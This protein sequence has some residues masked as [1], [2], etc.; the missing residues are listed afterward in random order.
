MARYKDIDA[1]FPERI[2]AAKERQEQHRQDMERL[3]MERLCANTKAAEGFMAERLA[4]ALALRSRGQ[5]Y[6]LAVTLLALCFT[7]VMSLYGHDGT[8]TT[9]GGFTIASLAVA[10]ITD[11]VTGKS[12]SL[13]AE[14]K[15]D[16]H[17]NETPT[18]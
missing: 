7:L 3:Q 10:F 12:R 13:A 9:I 2:M 11:R 16:T 14:S 6:A 8:A 4:G 18:S 5:H 17:S 15:A 1:S